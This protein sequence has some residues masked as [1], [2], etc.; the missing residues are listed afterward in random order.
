MAFSDAAATQALTDR[1]RYVKGSD[2]DIETFRA[3]RRELGKARHPLHYLAVPPALFGEVVGCLQ[4]SGCAAGARIIVEKPFGRDLASA[5]A[6]NETIH[7]VFAETDVFRID[8]YLGKEPVQNLLYFRFA[9]S[10]LEPL[11]NRDHVA[12]VQINMP[13]A[14]DVADRGA[15]YD[16]AGAIRDVV[17][18]HLLQVVS[19]LAMEPPSGHTPARPSATRSTRFSTPF[20]RSC[21]P[22]W[23]AANTRD[24]AT[25]TGVAADSSVETFVALQA[26]HRHAGAGPAC[27]STSEPASACPSLPPRSS[28]R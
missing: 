5:V 8:H 16:Q 25:R 18:N 21:R 28:W 3:L 27:R 6:L 20:A 17:Q 23:C 2:E 22:T 11:W 13:E 14:G 24:I 12:S 26:S 7:E 10:F 1:L 15:F 4:V 9:N 19:L